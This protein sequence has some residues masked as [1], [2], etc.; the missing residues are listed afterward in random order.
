MLGPRLQA[1]LRPDDTLAR[2]GGDEFVIVCADIHGSDKAEAIADR[3]DQALAVPFDVGGRAISI[4]ASIGVTL[5][6]AG[7]KPDELLGQAD[8]AMYSAKRRDRPRIK[9][10]EISREND[11]PDTSPDA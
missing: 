4:S 10:I 5:G 3:I 9:F 6:T 11:D 2:F 8:A 1:V 7:D